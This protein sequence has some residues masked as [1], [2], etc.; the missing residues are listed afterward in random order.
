MSEREQNQVLN[1]FSKNI[2][3]CWDTLK[4]VMWGIFNELLPTTYFGADVP[5]AVPPAPCDGLAKTN[6]LDFDSKSIKYEFSQGK[7][8]V[9]D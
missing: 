2:I 5:W 9:I 8:E 4:Q 3:Y 7:L 6:L 1:L